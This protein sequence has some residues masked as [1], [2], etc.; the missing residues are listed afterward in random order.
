MLRPCEKRGK[1]F[2]TGYQVVRVFTLWLV[3]ISF[4]ILTNFVNFLYYNFVHKRRKILNFTY[5]WAD[6]FFK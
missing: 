4:S 3:V 6:K 5:K 2:Y 1:Q